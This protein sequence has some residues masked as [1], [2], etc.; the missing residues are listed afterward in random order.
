MEALDWVVADGVDLPVPGDVVA[1]GD[2]KL[3]GIDRDWW[4]VEDGL[5][6]GCL[7]WEGNGAEL[8]KCVVSTWNGFVI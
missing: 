2:E 5:D 7:V 1:A 4:G 8:K 3:E 6:V